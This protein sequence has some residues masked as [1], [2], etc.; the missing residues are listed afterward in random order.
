MQAFQ[1][2]DRIFDL[3]PRFKNKSLFAL[4]FLTWR[5]KFVFEAY[6]GDKT[7]ICKKGFYTT[8]QFRIHTM[9]NCHCSK[10]FAH[11]NLLVRFK[12][13]KFMYFFFIQI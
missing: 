4:N 3:E 2:L 11:E 5:K 9:I 12:D 1:H 6:Y 10:L 13:L 7:Y 8:N